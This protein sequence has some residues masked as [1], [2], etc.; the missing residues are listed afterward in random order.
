M[1]PFLILLFFL[2]LQRCN[3]QDFI[4]A[5]QA[6]GSNEGN[7]FDDIAYGIA[8]D[9]AGNVF[10][11][12]NIVGSSGWNAVFGKN[13]P[14]ETILSINGMFVAKYDPT[15]KL[16]WVRQG[17]TNNNGVNGYGVATDNSGNCYVTGRFYNETKFGEGQPNETI[18]KGTLSEI[19][20]AKYDPEGILQWAKSAGGSGDADTGFAI[21]TDASANVYITGSIENNVTFGKGEASEKTVSS[22]GIKIFAAKFT[23]NGNFVWAN[24]IKTP[25]PGF[26]IALDHNS[27]LVVCGGDGN[28]IGMAKLTNNGVAVWEIVPFTESSGSAFGLAIDSYDN[29]YLTGN[30]FGKAA[31]DTGVGKTEITGVADDDFYIAKYRS[32]GKNLWARS[33]GGPSFDRGQSL[34]VDNQNSVYVTGY[35]N[36][37]LSFKGNN[38]VKLIGAEKHD[39][40]IAKYTHYGVLLWATNSSGSGY[41]EGKGI[42]VDEEGNSY[43]VG[44]SNSDDL[45]FGKGETAQLTFEASGYNDIYYAKF[46]ASNDIILATSK[47]QSDG[48]HVFPNPVTNEIQLSMILP[49]VSPIKIRIRDS[50]G[51]EI[52]NTSQIPHSREHTTM[53]NLANQPAGLYIIELQ[54][55]SLNFYNKIIKTY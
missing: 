21:V 24:S 33:A 49:D 53:I 44:Y 43:V 6:G 46:K 41:E 40:F 4:Y 12:G 14:N 34:A 42:A 47:E 20:I 16:L 50:S 26:S 32:D 25:G 8:L 52:Y 13:Q 23:S 9:K 39:I 51:K 54:T 55:Q 17:G 7:S 30:F 28:S 38:P 2:F 1:R 27:N 45:I 22:S 19:F 5:Q 36:K 37:E 18:L 31:F 10:I 15:G 29:I 35:F 11:T 48:M 3:A